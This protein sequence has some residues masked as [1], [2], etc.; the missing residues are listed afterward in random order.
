[1][2]DGSA[3]DDALHRDQRAKGIDQPVTVP[4]CAW[5]FCCS[6]PIA[7]C[8]GRSPKQRRTADDRNKAVDFVIGQMD[9]WSH[10]AVSAHIT[11]LSEQAL[12]VVSAEHPRISRAIELLAEKGI[13]PMA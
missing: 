5:A 12:E 13:A 8:T 9:D 6:S 1:M 10:E 3:V 7:R 11:L 4:A 2:V